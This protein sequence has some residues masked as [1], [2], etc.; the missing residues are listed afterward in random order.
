MKNKI[1]IG[2]R[3]SKL[4]LIYAK[5]AR[6]ELLKIQEIH[7]TLKSKDIFESTSNISLN[8]INEITNQVGF[9]IGSLLETSDQELVDL[10]FNTIS[11][12]VIS[13]HA[14]L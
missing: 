3:G 6:D 5:I 2:S 4:A 14:V 8:E 13:K 12:R 1:I 7:R 10:K 11:N 9:D